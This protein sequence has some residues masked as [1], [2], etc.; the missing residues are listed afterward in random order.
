MRDD[1]EQHHRDEL[2]RTVKATPK[3]TGTR[4]EKLRAIV[5]AH[6]AARVD[7]CF[8]DAF[9]ANACVTVFEALSEANR[10]TFVALPM[11]KMASVAFKLCK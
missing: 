8:V 6:Q 11:R 4:I 3:P 7:G 1:N 9:T 10:A 2:A 5:K